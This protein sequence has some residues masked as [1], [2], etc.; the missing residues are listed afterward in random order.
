MRRTKTIFGNI[1]EQI[2]DLGEKPIYFSG[3]REQVTHTIPE[4][5]LPFPEATLY[6]QSNGIPYN[7]KFT[8]VKHSND[9]RRNACAVLV[10]CGKK[11]HKQIFCNH[12]LLTYGVSWKLEAML[13]L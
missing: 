4:R 5:V 10:T 13:S 8:I 6:H 12:L 2:F 7:S 9:L 11:W 3:A 1:R